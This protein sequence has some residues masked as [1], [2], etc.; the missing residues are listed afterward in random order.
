MQIL[1][2][3]INHKTADIAVRE[4]LAF[5]DA[6]SCQALQALKAEHPEGEFVLLSTCNR[7][8]CYAALPDGPEPEVRR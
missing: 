4:R 8:E 7:V 6:L 3:G 1:L 5:D 2:V